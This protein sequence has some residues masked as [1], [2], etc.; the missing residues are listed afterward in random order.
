MTLVVLRSSVLA[1][2]FV[3]CSQV[4]ISRCFSQE[5]TRDVHTWD[6]Q[7]GEVLFSKQH[8]KSMQC[9]HDLL[10]ILSLITWLKQWLLCFSAVKHLFPPVF[11]P[12]S[13]E[14]VPNEVL[15]EVES[16]ALTPRGQS[17]YIHQYQ[18]KCW[19]L[20]TFSVGFCALFWTPSFFVCFVCVFKTSL[21][22]GTIKCSRLE[23]TQ[24]VQ[25][26]EN[27]TLIGQSQVSP[28]SPRVDKLSRIFC[29]FY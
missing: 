4:A 9:Q 25:L 22:F 14:G 26:I 3:E 16:Y 28:S 13:L 18:S 7:R 24:L 27:N 15:N 12:Q 6:G 17:I 21:V 11:L 1:R 29:T 8:T 2:C 20:Q 5:Q 19:P 23:L 10:L